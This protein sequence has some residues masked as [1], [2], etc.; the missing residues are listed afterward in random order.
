[1]KHNIN[2]YKLATRIWQAKIT[3]EFE[4]LSQGTVGYVLKV[5]EYSTITIFITKVRIT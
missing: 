5:A 1:M 2:T 3:K 4:G